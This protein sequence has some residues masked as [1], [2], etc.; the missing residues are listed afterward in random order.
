MLMAQTCSD[1][2]PARRS[3]TLSSCRS[4]LTLK[5]GRGRSG[6]VGGPIRRLPR[7]THW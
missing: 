4:R 3:P 1:E 5:A 7:I 2:S 6:W